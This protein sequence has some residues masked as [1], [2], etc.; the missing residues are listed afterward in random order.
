MLGAQIV[1]QAQQILPRPF[2]MLAEAIDQPKN[3]AHIHI[4]T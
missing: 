4:D 1:Q 3:G 2:H